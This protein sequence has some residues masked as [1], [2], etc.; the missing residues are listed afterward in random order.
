VQDWND[1][2]PLKPFAQAA[3]VALEDLRTP[4]GVRD[5][6]INAF[7]LVDKESGRADVKIAPSAGYP[8]GMIGN[9]APEEFAE[10]HGLV[11]TLGK[12]NAKRGIKKIMSAMGAVVAGGPNRRPTV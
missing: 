5:A 4:V 10:L 6:S 1:D 2:D 9:T 8:S 3:M 12:G 11:L 7:G